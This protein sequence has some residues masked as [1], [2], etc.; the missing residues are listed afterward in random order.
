MAQIS[1][2]DA[3]ALINDQ[4]MNEILQGLPA[5]SAAL[6]TFRTVNMGTKKARMPVIAT[7][8]T[9]GFVTELT[10]ATGVKPTSAQ[11]WGSK[12]LIVEEIAVI[13]PIHEDV[14]DDTEFDVWDEV[15]PEATE[16]IG[17]ALDAAVF[18]GVNK[19][20]TWPAA[21]VPQAITASNVYVEGT[22]AVDLA[23]DINQT[24][25]LVE[26][27][28]Y[29][30]NVQYARRTLRSRLRGLRD[31]NDAP[32][33]VS[34]LRSDGQAN[35]VYGEDIYWVSNGAWQPEDATMLVGDRTKAIL[36]IRQDVTFKILDQA[37][38]GTG[39]NQINLAERDMIALRCKM[40]VAFQ[41][42]AVPTRDNPSGGFPFAVLAPDADFS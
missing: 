26:A 4:D 5:A 8:P 10:D 15:R 28:G 24:W 41:W 6:S 1:R 31:E 14:F 11:T 42:A 3:E 7:L 17:A 33:F 22:S 12:E 2:A 37:T 29:D 20:A 23:E 25:A 9:A 35:S 30:V 18:F 34:S 38:L 40:R 36:G 21:L 16:A 32:I 19:P 27:D 13:I 39:E